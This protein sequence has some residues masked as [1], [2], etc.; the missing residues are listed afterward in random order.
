MKQ[1][2]QALIQ[3]VIANS[4]LEEFEYREW[5]VAYHLKIV[6]E[7]ALSLVEKY[8]E[9]DR[10]LTQVLAWVH[11]YSKPFAKT[12]EEE[13]EMLIPMLSEAMQSLDFEPDFIERTTQSLKEIES[14]DE[15][16]L[17]NAA[18]EV[19]IV[20]SADGASHFF[21][22]FFSSYFRDDK[23]EPL[24]RTMDRVIKKAQRD[25]NRKIVL[26]EARELVKDRYEILLDNMRARD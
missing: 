4:S 19:R 13:K 21:G 2:I 1:K 12:K 25:W 15:K 5:F 6:E 3:K 26:P 23:N 14:K 22:P 17:E 18:I 16:V 24:S 20:S 7:I 8:P 10:D 11:D 9:A